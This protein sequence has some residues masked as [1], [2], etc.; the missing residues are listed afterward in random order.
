MLTKLLQ[1]PNGSKFFRQYIATFLL[2]FFA[3]DFVLDSVPP[4]HAIRDFSACSAVSISSGGAGNPADDH[5]DCGLP[6][7]G[8][9][10]THHHHFPGVLSSS[11]LTIFVAALH[12]VTS[13]N[14]L[15]RGHSPASDLPI[16][17]PPCL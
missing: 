8:C 4:I 11:S 5:P 14:V 15:A 12:L 9:A 10:L 3:W 17:A 13:D 7:H 6:D 16:R 1:V 2:L